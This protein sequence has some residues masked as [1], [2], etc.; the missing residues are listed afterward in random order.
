MS[1]REELSEAVACCLWDIAPTNEGAVVGVSYIV[2]ADGTEGCGLCRCHL[3]HCVLGYVT[4]QG[5]VHGAGQQG[6]M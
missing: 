3:V 6:W 2:F 5:H 1:G 4:G